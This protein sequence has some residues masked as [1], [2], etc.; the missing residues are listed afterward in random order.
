MS[1]FSSGTHETVA[2]GSLPSGLTPEQLLAGGSRDIKGIQLPWNSF[3]KVPH[4]YEQRLRE[5]E[6]QSGSS[7][8]TGKGHLG[9]FCVRR[10]RDPGPGHSYLVGIRAICLS[11]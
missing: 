9:L 7:F 6:D 8:E 3:T 4:E 5:K 10:G 11:A 1:C 2:P